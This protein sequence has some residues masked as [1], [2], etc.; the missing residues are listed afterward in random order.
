MAGDLGRVP[1]DDLA[2]RLVKLYADVQR[3]IVTRITRAALAGDLYD[4]RRLQRQLAEILEVLETLGVQADPLAREAA[5]QAMA[6]GALDAAQ[7][8]RRIGVDLTGPGERAF[9]SVNSDAVRVAQDAILG[10]LQGARYTV[11]RQVEDVFAREGR[12][13]T[14][15]ALLGGDGSSQKAAK[16]MAAR[17]AAQ[18]QT[19]LIDK[20]GRRWSLAHYSDMAV[21]TTTREAVVRGAVNRMVAHDV[22]IGRISVHPNPCSICA[23]YQGRYIDLTGDGPSTYMGSPVM[24]AGSLAPYHPFCAHTVQAAVT[25]F[26]AIRASAGGP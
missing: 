14:M 2:D 19:A 4:Q 3:D 5:A 6:D 9:A 23:P 10:R 22:T 11:G 15:R 1:S 20:A 12:E 18:G 25:R 8:I 17:L 21:R 13:Q 26:D 7:G 16:R 24:D